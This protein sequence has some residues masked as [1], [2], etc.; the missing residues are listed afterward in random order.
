MRETFNVI[1]SQLREWAWE[2]CFRFGTE[3]NYER[4]RWGL[5]LKSFS[6]V[7]LWLIMCHFRDLFLLLC[8]GLV[9]LATPCDL[10]GL[11]SLMRNWTWVLGSASTETWPLDCQGILSGTRNWIFSWSQSCVLVPQSG[12]TLCDPM[13]F[14]PPGP[15]SVNSL[16]KNTGVG[17]HSLLQEIFPTQWLN[18]GLLH[19]RQIL[20]HVSHQGSPLIPNVSVMTKE[21]L[22]L[23]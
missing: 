21:V 14:S 8:C 17:G 3:S 10:Q 2:I 13:D 1:G 4:A 20:Y 22:V 12:P 6:S 16:G 15:L 5:G 11:S 23:L 19:C 18:P 9:F 7:S